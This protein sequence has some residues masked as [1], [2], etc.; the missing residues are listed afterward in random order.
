MMM[1][2]LYI[3]VK[4]HQIDLQSAKCIPILIYGLSLPPIIH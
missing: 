1:M 2:N 4:R 3:S